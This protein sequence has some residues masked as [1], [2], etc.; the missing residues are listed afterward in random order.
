MLEELL[1]E[2][3]QKKDLIEGKIKKLAEES[4][5]LQQEVDQLQADQKEDDVSFLQVRSG[6]NCLSPESA[7][8]IP[9]PQPSGSFLFV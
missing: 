5:V 1:A 9:P 7:G 8:K 6:D 2:T 4:N 3:K